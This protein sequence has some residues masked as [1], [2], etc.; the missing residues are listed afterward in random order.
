MPVSISAKIRTEWFKNK[1]NRPQ[2]Q[3]LVIVDGNFYETANQ[4]HHF[5]SLRTLCGAVHGG[6]S[7]VV[8]RDL[9]F[10]LPASDHRAPDR[11]RLVLSADRRCRLSLQDAGSA[12][13]LPPFFI[14]E[15]PRTSGALL[16]YLP[17]SR[18]SCAATGDSASSAVRFGSAIR[19][20]R[21]SARSHTV[22]SSITAPTTAKAANTR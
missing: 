12:L 11:R 13:F 6:Y 18:H 10:P 17:L 21:V 9:S 14:R 1:A 22:P 19:P 3:Y 4:N 16:L 8:R 20:L 2:W 5:H 7:H 15:V